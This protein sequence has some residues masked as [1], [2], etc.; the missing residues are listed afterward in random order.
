MGSDAVNRWADSIRWPGL[1]PF[2]LSSVLYEVTA[3]CNLACPHCYNV[4]KNDTGYPV[5]EL[6]TEGAKRLITK[7]LRESRCDQLT[8]TGGEPCL[9]EDLESLVAHAKAKV[10]HVILI[11]NGT[12]LDEGRIRSLLKAGVDLFELPLHGGDPATHDAA[13][14]YLGSFDLVTRAA[15]TIRRLGG[16][17]A[18]VFVG[19]RANID[20]WE[21]A[22]EVGIALGARSF[23]FNRWNAGGACHER[24][25]DLMPSVDQVLAAL[26]VAEACIQ[27]YGVAISASIPLPP[28][29][30][31]MTPYPNVASGFCSAGGAQAYFT[32]DPMGR[33]RPCNH[34]STVLGN[35]LEQPFRRL[36][37]GQALED[38]V[39]AR[40][41]FCAGC[42]M[43]PTCMGG[44]KA[45]AEACHGDLRACDPFLALNLDRVHRP[46]H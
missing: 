22:L 46:G 24:P 33:V 32:L 3:R 34:T 36:A 5:A 29:L 16:H 23:L 30:V 21:S 20:Q 6:D 40:P 10:R 41:A 18:F 42:A 1:R 39:A 14:G 28:C 8:M 2:R 44:C 38:F 12:L 31:D 35:L 25:E 9:R 27:R 11:S 43:E 19:K 17:L 45:A 13:L 26:A 37:R 15:T 7:A 4:W